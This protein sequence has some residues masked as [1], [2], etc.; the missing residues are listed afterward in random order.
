[1]RSEHAAPA[2]R[3]ERLSR[4][5]DYE[6]ERGEPDPR[7]WTVVNREGRAVG[8]VKDLIVDTERMVATYLD[9]ELDTKIFDL[10]DDDPHVF[11]PV[12]GARADHKRLVVDEITGDWVTELRAM[13]EVH[14]LEFWDRWWHRTETRRDSETRP[15]R[16]QRTASAP[17][18]N[19][20]RAIRDV[21]PGEEVRFPVVKE[22][23]VVE[24]RAVDREEVVVNR[25]DDQPPRRR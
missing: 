14:W 3:L 12:E 1:M 25:A 7:G 9:V 21:R 11:V 24:R 20:Q 17:E 22:E 19:L 8:E 2:K 18:D 23:I 4:L 6:V 10:R 15:V 5:R 16:I 13:R